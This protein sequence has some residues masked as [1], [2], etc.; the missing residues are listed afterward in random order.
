M[1]RFFNN[2][3]KSIATLT[4]AAVAATLAAAPA[5]AQLSAL[6]NSPKPVEP[7]VTPTQESA[8]T[9]SPMVGAWQGGVQ[10]PQGNMTL[11]MMVFPDGTYKARIVTEMAPGPN[12]PTAPTS[13][14]F[15]G[16]WKVE[17]REM[18]T[19][20]DAD[21]SVERNEFELQGNTLV[22][23]RMAPGGADLTLVRVQVDV[24]PSNGP[25][26]P[27]SGPI[28]PNGRPESGLSGDPKIPGRGPNVPNPQPEA[29]A[30]VVGT[31]YGSG[32]VQ[33]LQMDCKVEILPNGDYQSQ[34]NIRNGR[35]NN[36][37]SEQ[38]TWKM[39]GRKILFESDEESTYIPFKV[40]GD[41]LIL[42]YSEE[43]GIIA[44]LSQTPGKG[45]IRQIEQDYGY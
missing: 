33:G 23:K 45:Q 22:L 18:I 10:G 27:H 37:I 11:Q 4:L 14:V 3:G 32:I 31:W 26:G 16:Q 40:E 29:M 25:V 35:V 38:G 41:V 36:Q 21:N 30:P 24:P 39:R 9:V 20:V 28:G 6:K 7:N 42:D 44:I 5:S 43:E 19:T 13:N 2:F 15:G 34:I 8:P 12:G 17:G 1:K